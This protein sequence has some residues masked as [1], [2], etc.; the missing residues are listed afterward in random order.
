MITSCFFLKSF[1]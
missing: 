1:N